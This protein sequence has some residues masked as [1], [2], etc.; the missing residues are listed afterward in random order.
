MSQKQSNPE[1]VKK[2]EIAQWMLD[3]LR[4]HDTLY[5]NVAAADIAELFGSEFTYINDAGNVAI[6]KQVLKE[7]RI[8][9]SEDV[10]WDQGSRYWRWREDYDTVGKRQAD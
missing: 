3:Q 2:K 10:V 5:Q 8:L 9:T 6:D 4:Q 1:D 7:F